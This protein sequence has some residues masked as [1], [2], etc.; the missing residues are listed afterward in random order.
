MEV[1]AISGKGQSSLIQFT[2]TETWMLLGLVQLWPEPAIWAFSSLSFCQAKNVNVLLIGLIVPWNAL[3]FRHNT[4]CK[5]YYLKSGLCCWELRQISICK[6]LCMLFTELGKQIAKKWQRGV[7]EVG[8]GFTEHPNV[9][10]DSSCFLIFV[11]NKALSKLGP[12]IC[13]LEVM[14]KYF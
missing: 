7:Q 5:I 2:G 3:A 13:P 6:M 9:S 4:G 8:F 1:H 10:W 12:C 14:F 11:P